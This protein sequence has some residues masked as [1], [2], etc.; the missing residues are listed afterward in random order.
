MMEGDFESVKTLISKYISSD[1]SID[2]IEEKAFLE[3][4]AN[5]VAELMENNME[6]FFNHLYRMDVDERKVAHVLKY[7]NNDDESVYMS[8]ARLIY[9]R[10]ILRME[11]KKRFKQ[12]DIDFWA[13]E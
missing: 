11:T 1:P 12:E 3:M 5:R 13:E 7:D 4:I 2:T 10:Q 8:I 6:L 9:K